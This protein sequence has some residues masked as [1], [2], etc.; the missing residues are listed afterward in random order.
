MHVHKQADLQ[1]YT[2]HMTTK[3][4]GRPAGERGKETRLCHCFLASH[5]PPRHQ[6]S[7]QA[8]L[9]PA[10]FPQTQLL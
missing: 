1:K 2:K 10:G 5:R 8:L 9:P 6:L 3:V 4:E 7:K